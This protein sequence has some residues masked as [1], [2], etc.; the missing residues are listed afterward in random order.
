MAKLLYL[1]ETK[2]EISVLVISNIKLRSIKTNYLALPRSGTASLVLVIM[3]PTMSEKTTCDSRMVTPRTKDRP[4]SRFRGG[5]LYGL[6]VPIRP[7]KLSIRPSSAPIL[8]HSM[9][10]EETI[11]QFGR[12]NRYQWTVL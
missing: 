6:Y 4:K 7:C 9:G 3:R 1:G 8:V 12:L 2:R 5:C 10:G 11:T